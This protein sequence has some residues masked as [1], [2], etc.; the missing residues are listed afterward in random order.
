MDKDQIIYQLFKL[1]DDIDTM[2]DI[3]K[4]DDRF[5]RAK[6]EHLQAK[7]FL[8]L[9]DQKYIDQLYDKYYP[10]HESAVDED[11]ISLIQG[12]P[13]QDLREAPS[14]PTE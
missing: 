9:T 11:I 2:S 1:L 4:D 13:L 3:A 14:I 10:K 6:V 8:V 7:R 12:T 5:Y